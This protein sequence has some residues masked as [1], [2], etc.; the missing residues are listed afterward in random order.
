MAGRQEIGHVSNDEGGQQAPEVKTSSQGR[1]AISLKFEKD[2]YP[3]IEVLFVVGGLPSV[4]H[5]F[6]LLR[7]NS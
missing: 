3:T 4:Q 6:E 2:A 7:R 1:G 5:V